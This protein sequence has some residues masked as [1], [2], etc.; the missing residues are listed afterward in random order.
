MKNTDKKT[1]NLGI[2]AIVICAITFIWFSLRPGLMGT[3]TKARAV[4]IGSTGIVST[5]AGMASMGSGCLFLCSRS[6]SRCALVRLRLNW[7][8][9]LSPTD[10]G[11]SDSTS[12]VRNT[13]L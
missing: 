12:L 3:F 7:K 13:P 10:Q 1:F 8:D 4:S 6:Y 5:G 11:W 2:I 9:S